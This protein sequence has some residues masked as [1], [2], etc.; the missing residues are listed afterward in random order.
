M[1]A[2]IRWFS[3]IRCI[4]ILLVLIY[5][6]FKDYLPGGFI[7][8][9]VFLTLSGFLITAQIADNL[10]ANGG[11]KFN[12]FIKRRIK[13]VYPTFFIMV[14]ICLPMVMLIS[15]D[16]SAS[17]SKQAAAALSFVTNYYEIQS[18]GSYEAQMLPHIFVHTWFLAVEMQICIAWGLILAAIA[19]YAKKHRINSRR[20]IFTLSAAFA[21]LSYIHMQLLYNANPLNPSIAYFGSTSRAFPFFI[22]A[23]T[24]TL[25][26]TRVEDDLKIKLKSRSLQCMIICAVIG[27]LAVLIA[28][29]LI[30]DFSG[31]AAYRWGMLAASFLTAALIRLLR[32]VHAFTPEYIKEPVPLSFMSD[33]SFGVYLFHWPLYIVFFNLPLMLGNATAAVAAFTVSLLMS[34]IVAYWLKMVFRSRKS[35]LIRAVPVII[36]VCLVALSGFALFRAPAISS[37]ERNLYIAYLRQDSDTLYDDYMFINESGN[38]GSGVVSSMGPIPLGEDAEISSESILGVQPSAQD[39]G[40]EYSGAPAT[41]SI[42]QSSPPASADTAQSYPSVTTDPAGLPTLAPTESTQPYQTQEPSAHPGAIEEEDI[43]IIG[44]SVLLGARTALLDALPGIVVNAEGSRQMWQG[45]EYIMQLQEEGALREC[46]VIALGTNGN[47]NS[48]EYIEKIIADII[49]GHRL[50]FVA[51]YNGQGG[52]RSV[53]YRTA[54]YIRTLPGIYDFV[55]VA[56]WSALILPNPE[57]LGSDKIHIDGNEAAIELF[58]N[59]VIDAL[60]VASTK[61]AKP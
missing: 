22:G 47:E 32:R 38:T 51:P 1:T 35:R 13:R 30:V 42:T 25:T 20:I 49:P 54:V 45:Y 50:I 2:K 21:I 58:V 23:M 37:I 9:D 11:F 6:F 55:T 31:A 4:G 57:A 27:A 19:R 16:F 8:V 5:H 3:I 40:S 56:D 60:H 52:E 15:P 24:G 26:G 34:V 39:S 44:D 33:M 36:I 10:R 59:C 17:I 53:T 14:I 29:S 46:V 61:P 28:I 48:F 41:A 43:L 18:G 12:S 7:G